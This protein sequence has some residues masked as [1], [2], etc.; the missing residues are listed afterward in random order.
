[1][2]DLAKAPNKLGPDDL[3]RMNAWWWVAKCLDEGSV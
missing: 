3:H 2:N 1:M